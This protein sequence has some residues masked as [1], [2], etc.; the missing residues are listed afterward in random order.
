MT[1]VISG[2]RLLV[3]CFYN[4]SMLLELAG[5]KSSL[6]W[7]GKSSSE[8]NTDGLHAIVNTPVIAGEQIDREEGRLRSCS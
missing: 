4:G 8:I 5:E 3:S 1:P 6:I 7:K 2:S